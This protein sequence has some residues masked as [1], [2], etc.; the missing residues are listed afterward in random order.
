MR[1]KRRFDFDEDELDELD[2]DAAGGHRTPA[3]LERNARTPAAHAEP[4]HHTAGAL[5]P[6]SIIDRI[7][8]SADVAA[9]SSSQ[10]ARSPPA[11]RGSDLLS[12]RAGKQ[13]TSQPRQE[14]TPSGGAI[15]RLWDAR[16]ESTEPTFGS[17]R[18]SQSACL[19]GSP[20]EASEWAGGTHVTSQERS[21]SQGAGSHGARSARRD[22]A[23]SA[24]DYARQV[25]LSLP[26]P[27]PARAHMP[28]SQQASGHDFEL[29][30]A[31]G[32]WGAESARSRA[33]RGP[34]LGDFDAVSNVNPWNSQLYGENQ[35][36]PRVPGPAGKLGR[37]GAVPSK[38]DGRVSPILH[39]RGA[40]AQEAAPEMREGIAFDAAGPLLPLRRTFLVRTHRSRFRTRWHP[41]SPGLLGQLIFKLREP[42]SCRR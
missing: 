30:H 9:S 5:A 12:R 17:P 3:S 27:T 25:L 2:G 32:G 34:I 8:A 36:R 16:V 33:G 13:S 35:P 42:L 22:D 31:A 7:W 37:N 4:Q 38:T 29:H 18:H 19:W 15:D 40:A 24:D 11:Q 41:S 21:F 14:Q 10:I 28:L 20:S 6:A 26:K 23:A 1:G 39:E